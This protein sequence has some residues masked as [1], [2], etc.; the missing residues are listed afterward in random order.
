MTG[1]CWFV[2]I[3][4]Y[5]LFK[6]I[7]KES[8]PLYQ[9]K[10]YNTAIITI[11]TMIVEMISGLYLIYIFGSKLLILNMILFGL[12][13]V[14][15]MILQ[16]PTHLKLKDHP[17]EKSFNFLIRTNWIRT[18]LWTIRSGVLIY[19]ITNFIQL[20]ELPIPAKR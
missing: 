4:H 20:L 18:I 16:V 5:P 19:L 7:P 15:T 10:N 17:N 13:M 9:R 8:F 12:I 6:D 3:V 1:L 2:Q 11:P 14:S